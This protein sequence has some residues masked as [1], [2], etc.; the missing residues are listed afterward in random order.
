MLKFPFLFFELVITMGSIFNLYNISFG[1][2]LVISRGDH[3][4]TFFY[5]DG[6]DFSSTMTLGLTL[7]FHFG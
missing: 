1:G 2:T 4:K 3:V 5:S 7:S 6:N